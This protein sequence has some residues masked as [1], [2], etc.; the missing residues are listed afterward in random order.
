VQFDDIDPH[1]VVVDA[2]VAERSAP[3]ERCNTDPPARITRY[4]LETR[5][6]FFDNDE[7]SQG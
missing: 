3:C 6:Q 1:E 2:K 5:D 4:P 7:A